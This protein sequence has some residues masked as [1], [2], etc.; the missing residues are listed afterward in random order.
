MSVMSQVCSWLVTHGEG[1]QFRTRDIVSALGLQS[2]RV[3]TA[4]SSLADTGAVRIV[5]AHHG[6]GG[7]LFE[8]AQ[9]EPIRL[10]TFTAPNEDEEHL[11]FAIDHDGDLQILRPDGSMTL[12]DNAN[13]RRLVA[14]VALQASAILT[15]GAQ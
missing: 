2:D 12:I 13:A 11:T 8:V 4:L 5:E 14:F 1:L 9:M 10:R 3:S 7:N 15:A 6:R